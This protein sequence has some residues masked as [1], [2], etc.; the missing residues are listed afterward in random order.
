MNGKKLSI[1]TLFSMI[2]GAAIFVSP[3]IAM[4]DDVCKAKCQLDYKRCEKN[5]NGDTDCMLNCS[6]TKDSCI[7]NCGN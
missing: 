1:T 6:D 4:A 3:G 7:Q 5:C 2:F